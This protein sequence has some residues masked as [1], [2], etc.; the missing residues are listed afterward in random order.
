M[1]ESICLQTQRCILRP[2]AAADTETMYRIWSDVEV[3][4][5]MVMDPFQSVDQ[6]VAM[7]SLLNNLPA[8]DEGMRWAIEER[9]SCRAIGTCGFH[10][11]S[12]EHR[13]AEIGYEIDR[14]FWGQGLIQE[15]L[16][17]LLS[18]CYRTLNLNRIEALV[19]K[20]NHRSAGL[21]TSL[22][23]RP[24]GIL[25]DYEWARGRFQDQIIFSFLKREWE[26]CS[27][28]NKS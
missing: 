24:E 9:H 27:A 13:K 17:A 23:F 16:K 3:T 22:G 4:E 7:I 6:A 5:Y 8:S 11:A 28:N 20:G 10:K 15:A 25:R 18:H 1:I 2:I 12:F 19:T 21:L 14:A 26:L